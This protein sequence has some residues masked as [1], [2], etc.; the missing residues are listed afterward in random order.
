MSGEHDRECVAYF[1]MEI[2]ISHSIPTYAGGLGILAGDLLK[3]FAD[4]HVSMVG[5]T[6]LNSKGYFNQAI[7]ASGNQI[8]SPVDWKVS[9]FMLLMPNIVNIK[10]D[11][12]DVK[13]RAWR[14]IIRG[15]T[16]FNVP[17]FFLDSNIEGNSEYD[18]T[19][20]SNL[21]SGDRYYR[22]SQEIILGI[23]GVRMLESLGFRG[24]KKYHMNEGHSSLL[25]VEL[26]NK[27]YNNTG[28]NEEDCYDVAGVR[29]RC[30]F[31][32]H[33]PIAAGHDTFDLNLFQKLLQGYMPKFVLDRATHNGVAN[34]T[35]LGINFSKYI[36]GVA[37]SHGELT[38]E[39]F[40]GYV[41]DDI[42]NGIHPQTWISPPFKALYDKYI[43][44]WVKDPFTLRYALSI[45]KEEMLN[46]HLEA[47]KQLI[48]EVNQKTGM[49]FHPLRFTIG[50]A[51]RFTEYKRPDMIIQD[52][53]RLKQI[54]E[55]VGDIQ[56]IFSGK[57]HVQ[58]YKGKELI[59]KIIETAGGINRENCHVKIAFLQNYDMLVARRMVAG[60]DVWLN[61]PQRPLE[62][63][64]TSGMKAALNGVPQ[65][66]TLDGWWLE[67]CVENLTGWSL[68]A[69]PQDPGF[70]NDPDMVDES[71]DL[72]DKLE[73]TIIPTFYG[74]RE[75]WADIMRHCIAIN[76]SFFNTYR[77]AQQYMA[78][79]YMN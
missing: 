34:M 55:K 36:N 59:K 48:D 26:L 77:M 21:Y 35:L 5:V 32:T 66:S 16:G 8:E 29:E 49:D 27:T 17:V 9:D 44:G 41:I 6:L 39:M 56:I 50:Y 65:M 54:A 7:D 40:P 68:G 18:R 37:K 78:N 33:T 75:R 15:A 76:A 10:I 62:A 3:S 12:R 43:P 13:I 46:A 38:R 4:M 73:N 64:G 23:G 53:G 25:T 70:K 74:N 63:S 20:T 47:K 31:T 67:G 79:A 61:N 28:G 57:A 1:S 24:I 58:D 42:T 22:L 69:H 52:I 19:L 72:Y 45:P 51:R 2:G 60:C 30:V 71:R 11:G 14:H